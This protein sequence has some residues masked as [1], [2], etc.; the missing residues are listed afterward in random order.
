MVECLKEPPFSANQQMTAPP[1][2]R[3]ALFA[4]AFALLGGLTAAGA[5]TPENVRQQIDQVRATL[6]DIDAAFKSPY[7]SDV[8]L[9][10]LRSE[11]HP[12]AGIVQGVI[13]EL[14]P[15]L[16]ASTKRLTELTPK[17]KDK[18]ETDAVATEI[19]AEQKVHDDL[20]GSMRTA[21]AL[22]VQV[23]ETNSRI[24]AARRALFASQVFARSSSI[25]SPA[26]W[27][28]VAHETPADWTAFANLVGAWLSGDVSRLG[29]GQWLG[30]L[31][32]AIA[33]AALAPPLRWVAQRVITRDP[34]LAAPG[35]LRRAITAL[36]TILVL[37]CLPLLALVLL[38]YAL[39]AFDI[40]DPRL[41]GVQE[42]FFDGLKLIF[43][44]NAIARG[45]LALKRPAWRLVDLSEPVVQRIWR[46]WI[47]V[48]A[49]VALERVL[50]P[51]DDAVAASL[52]VTVAT[53]GACALAAALLMAHSLRGVYAPT[54]DA[55]LSSQSPRD[56]W[57]PV[58]A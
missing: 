42:A 58:R 5:Q 30:F 19:A 16:A 51:I 52:S 10:R 1:P 7:L 20:D 46:V 32:L 25:L 29:W 22:A 49:I 44:A 57:A 18:V 50:E 2:F 38:N 24:G 12:L 55:L 54:E 27:I 47:G 36:W 34:A 6:L 11:N 14:A 41:Q 28:S 13:D 43:V 3:A 40:S 9:L 23:D 21:R 37:A 56:A 33:M 35:K 26:L 53:R 8:E 39:D 48:A 17:S 45:L 4:L 31:A 15:K